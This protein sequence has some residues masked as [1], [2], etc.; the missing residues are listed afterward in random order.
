[1][2]SGS[3]GKLAPEV[4]MLGPAQKRFQG[5][6]FLPEQS[7]GPGRQPDFEQILNWKF[8]VVT[9]RAPQGVTNT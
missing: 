7:V 3:L 4:K 8:C 6:S 9:R 5:S 2:C 1:M